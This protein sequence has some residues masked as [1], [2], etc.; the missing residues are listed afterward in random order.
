MIDLKEIVR[1]WLGI[2]KIDSDLGALYKILIEAQEGEIFLRD[3][4]FAA[5]KSHKAIRKCPTINK[6]MF[7]REQ[8]LEAQKKRTRKDRPLRIYKCEFCNLWHLTHKKTI[9]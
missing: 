5:T 1:K 9:V 3:D 8:A 2:N 6:F 4:L 7:T